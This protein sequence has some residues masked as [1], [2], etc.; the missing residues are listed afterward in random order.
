MKRSYEYYTEIE[1]NHELYYLEYYQFKFDP[2][3]IIR[4]IEIHFR[5]KKR[6]KMTKRGKDTK[7]DIDEWYR[8]TKKISAKDSKGLNVLKETKE[9]TPH[10]K[11]Q[12]FEREVNRILKEGGMTTTLSTAGYF[13]KSKDKYIIIGDGGIDISG[14]YKGT[15]FIIQCKCHKSPISAGVVRD[16][17]GVL[18]D[19]PNTIGVICAIEYS[20]SAIREANNTRQN[21]LLTT[22][23]DILQQ[24]QLTALRMPRGS[25]EIVMTYQIATNIEYNERFVKIDEARNGEIVFRF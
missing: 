18:L 8:Q 6:I 9:M 15:N 22:L 23:D 2:I 4:Y 24:I 21:I 16:L 3:R 5:P 11:G 13:D 14:N 7:D 25:K 1:I 12:W 10:Q 20:D 19:R 17:K